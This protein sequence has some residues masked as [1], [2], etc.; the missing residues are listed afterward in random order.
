MSLTL[1]TLGKLEILWNGYPVPQLKLRKSQALL[2]YLA[3]NPGGHDRS[4]LA[5]LLWGDLPEKSARRNLRHALHRLRDALAPEVLDSDRLSAG[6]NPDVPTQ[7]DALDFE[8]LIARADRCQREENSAAAISCL[9]AA[10]ELY[11][12][13]FLSGFDIAD[14]LEFETWVTRRRARMRE[15]ILEILDTL[16]THW[17]QRGAHERALGYARRM[18]GLEPLWEQSHR[19]MMTLL[20]LTGQRSAALAQYQE[21]RRL[22]E[23]ELGLEP[24]EETQALYARLVNWEASRSVGQVISRPV[25][26]YQSTNL[27]FTGREEEHAALM[28]AWE[29]A[30]RSTGQQLT[31]VEGEAGLGKTRLVDEVI[32]TIEPQGVVALRGRC[33]EFGGTLPYQPI[34]A[35]LRACLPE[36]ATQGPGEKSSP[37]SSLTHALS[38]IWLSELSRLLPELRQIYPDLP[39]PAPAPGEAARQRL[40]E[41]VTRLVLSFAN[42]SLVIFLDDLHWCDQS[43]L[44]L[45]HYLVRS[46]EDTS[47]WFVGTYRPEELSLSHPLTRLRQGL[48][49]DHRVKRLKLETL[50]GESVRAL[51]R[52]L[53]GERD[54]AS[55]GD[56]LYRE[57]E[58]NPFILVETV[59]DL[60]ERGA[61]VAE[62]VNLR[63]AESTPDD[64]HLSWSGPPTQETLPTGVQD[65]IL[66]R[67]GR[68]SEQAQRV[69]TLAAVVG[70][71]FSITLLSTA[72][73]QDTVTIEKSLNECLRRRLVEPCAHSAIQILTSDLNPLAS[74]FQYDFSHNKIRAV[75]YHATGSEHRRRL[76]RRVGEALEQIFSDRIDEHLGALAYHWE[77]AQEP[78]RATAYLLRAGDQARLLYAHQQAA[79]Y[80]RRVL[81]ILEGQGDVGRE[82]VA[83]TL[84]KLGLAH[85]GAFDFEQARQVYREGFD[86]WQQME[87]TQPA[88]VLPPAPHP[89]RLR[90]LE[91][92]TL[93]PAL[94]P[95][96]HTSCVLM[97][98][99]SGL[100]TL[101]PKMNI[102]PDVAQSWDLSEDGRRYTFHLRGDNRWS[103][104]APVTARDFE[105]AWKRVLDPATRSPSAHFLHDIRGAR[106]FHRGEGTSDAVG[107][108]ALDEAT[109]LVELEEPSGYFLQLLV[110]PD[111]YPVPR[112]AIKAHGAAWTELTHF[113]TNGPFRLERWRRNEQLILARNP[114][115]HGR[116]GGN[117]S[118]VTLFSLTDWSTRLQMY[119]EN[120]LDL[121]GIG[122][123]PPEQ[124]QAIRVQHAE[125]YVPFP[126]LESCY[127]AFDVNRAP[128]DDVRVRRA[129]TLATDRETLAEQV[130]QGYVAPALGGLLPHGMP[131]HSPD[132]GLPYDPERA[133]RLLVEAGYPGGRG[134]PAVNALAFD[135]VE[136]RVAYLTS[137][138]RD[139]LGVQVTWQ[140]PKWTT[141]VHK[142]KS[143][144]NH[145]V[146]AMWVADYPDPDNFLRVSRAEIWPG[147][148]DAR[149]ER[150][151]TEAGRA[152]DQE[153]RMRLYRQAD[154]ILVAEAPIMPLTYEREHLLVKPWVRH[155][156]L[157]AN[158]AVFWKDVVIEPYP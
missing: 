87:A 19:Q 140:A 109:L 157:T 151:V 81:A 16:V 102:V 60:Q 95:D 29:S 40:F 44:D 66:Q 118:Q 82:R 91:P 34:A 6:L 63:Y 143:E 49:R 106:A 2:I 113:V 98:L 59:N 10:A 76:H 122:F 114:D 12:S 8:A 9:E 71:P 15:Q 120:E 88:N 73:G 31:L 153:E 4:H 105:Y 150:L 84:M 42:S 107:V 50:S 158:K 97:Q 37:S 112:H 38:P 115:Y 77:Q 25:A 142:L 89:L 3:L 67:V 22:L 54:E 74:G 51:A 90:W 131:G 117:V 68:L 100:V 13:D 64:R 130:L 110:R 149:Y 116:F 104:G 144:P 75:V 134:F 72:T 83:R 93:D 138:W 147:W 85:H 18:L 36:Q 92:S 56:F 119:E 132:I 96:N 121:L 70:Q 65:V 124:R 94:S 135:A 46:V 43:T 152:M 11:Q 137:Q 108:R 145:L 48:G 128:F 52:S 111:Y 61:L 57:S 148:R 141:F 62:E 17:A 123:C 80:Y 133:R 79:D 26:P 154:A 5:G 28:S 7:V 129:F 69:L 1:N 21:C 53:V 99:F 39:E 35:A 47:I 156:P 20:A 146:Y 126:I 155:Y 33:Y 41:A 32:R 24:L 45:L 136:A 127:L 125:A 86:L 23:D 103:D 27:P 30:R 101:T 58:G 55:L 139:I 14:C 78:E